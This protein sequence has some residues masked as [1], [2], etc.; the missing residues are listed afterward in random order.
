MGECIMCGAAV[1]RAPAPGDDWGWADS[2]GSLVG[3]ADPHLY[4]RLSAARDAVLTDELAA[5]YYSNTTAALSLGC[6]VAT[7]AHY[8][9]AHEDGLIVAPWC[10][11]EPMRLRP[12]GWHCR[13]AC[14][15][16]AEAGLD[17]KV[18]Q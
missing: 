2:S 18:A 12:S 8:A 7:H 14:K 11:D 10:C 1:T 6:F 3:N 17:V 5:Q 13:K 4:E 9:I 16:P 15:S